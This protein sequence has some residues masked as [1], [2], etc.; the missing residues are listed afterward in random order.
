MGFLGSF[1][2]QVPCS[3]FARPNSFVHFFFFLN[4][5]VHFLLYQEVLFISF[6]PPKEMNQRKRGRK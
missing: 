5:F 2:C 3:F 1:A 4:S 6:A